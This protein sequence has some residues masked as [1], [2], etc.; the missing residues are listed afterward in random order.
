MKNAEKLSKWYPWE[1]NANPTY[2]F[3]NGGTTGKGSKSITHPSSVRHILKVGERLQ[4]LS[5]VMMGN[6]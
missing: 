2:Y 1:W 3:G 5:C 6:S 4:N